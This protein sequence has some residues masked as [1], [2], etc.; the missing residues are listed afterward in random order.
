VTLGAPPALELES[1]EFSKCSGCT[2]IFWWGPKTD[3]KLSDIR[4][5][6]ELESTSQAQF[7]SSIGIGINESLF[8]H[9]L[10]LQSAYK[11]CLGEEP[12]FTNFTPEFVD[13]LDYI[14]FSPDSLEC[15]SVAVRGQ[16]DTMLCSVADELCYCSL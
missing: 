6:L 7:S 16:Q 4:R 8:S 1:E 15:V 13:T 3:N 14:M 11:I 9:S 5:I 12:E 2:Q 10:R